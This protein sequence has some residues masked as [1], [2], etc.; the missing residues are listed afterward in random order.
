M[1]TTPTARRR[2][3]RRAN[4]ASVLSHCTQSAQTISELAR[5]SD[6]TRPGA[7]AV[8]S[9]LKA[10]GWISETAPPDT[11]SSLGRPASYY[12]LAPSSGHVLAISFGAH[13][14]GVMTTTL[15]GEILTDYEESCQEE[16]PTQQRL[17]RGITL[18]KHAQ[19]AAPGSTLICSVATPGIVHDGTVTYFGGHGMPGWVGTN[20]ASALS[21]AL[22]TKTIVAGDCALGARGESWKGAAAG[23]DNVLYILAGRR[24]GAAA[25]ISGRVHGGFQGSAGLIGELPA[26]QW[27]DL[28]NECFATHLYPKGQPPRVE[29]FPA[30]QAGDQQALAAID[31]YIDVLSLGTAAMILALAPQCVV[32]GGRFAAYSELIVPGLEE[33][34]SQI[35]PFMPT[36]T[37]SQLAGKEIILGAAR[38]GLDAINDALA[39]LVHEADYFPSPTPGSLW[40]GE[41]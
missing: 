32:L 34:L 40:E 19:E 20:L 23:L 41:Y 18:A 24:T 4:M 13:H 38:Y 37:A 26:L 6:L 1:T 35:C 31:A 22:S 33:R 9:D 14:I 7:E 3:Q 16:T 15:N 2:I 28:E 36:I 25:V 12:H 27:R 17:D 10:L 5:L 39:R 8:V 30:A 21:H 29:L 11:L